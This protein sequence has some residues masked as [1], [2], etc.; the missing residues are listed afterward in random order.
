MTSDNG[1]NKLETP[2]RIVEL[3]NYLRCNFYVSLQ[4]SSKN[5]LKRCSK[6]VLLESRTSKLTFLQFSSKKNFVKTFF[7]S[8]NQDCDNCH[9]Y[10]SAQCETQIL[11]SCMSQA[12]EPTHK[13]KDKLIFMNF[14]NEKVF[15]PLR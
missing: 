6:I 7:L 9:F 14:Q 15:F 2:Y 8:L 12:L 11:S 3:S 13:F 10:I 5:T 4:L 1:I